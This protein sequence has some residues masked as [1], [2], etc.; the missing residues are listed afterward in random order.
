M[1]DPGLRN[2]MLIAESTPLTQTRRLKIGQSHTR[3]VTMI[4]TGRKLGN[5]TFGQAGN[6]VNSSA[7]VSLLI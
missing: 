6:F 2:V 4:R 3:C 7:P 5:S 1:G